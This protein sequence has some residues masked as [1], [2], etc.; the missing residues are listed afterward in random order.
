MEEDANELD[1]IIVIGYGS[2]KKSNITGAI[3][4]VTASE[5]ADQPILRVDQTLQGRTTGVVVAA[6]SGQPG[7]SSTV[8]VRGITSLNGGANQPLWVI[9]GVVVDNGGID[10]SDL[11]TRWSQKSFNDK[12]TSLRARADGGKW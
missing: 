3:S 1:E 12:I 5:L 2:Q 8:L 11:R 6:N 4:S 10:P 7:S 9:D